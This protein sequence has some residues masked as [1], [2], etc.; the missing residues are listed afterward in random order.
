MHHNMAVAL[1]SKVLEMCKEE[2][3]N[4]DGSFNMGLNRCSH[5]I[6]QIEIAKKTQC[7]KEVDQLKYELCEQFETLEKLRTKKRML[8]D[9]QTAA[10]SKLLTVS[11]ALYEVCKQIK[12]I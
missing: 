3:E 11:D 6:R 1:F 12:G 7:S 4:L 10:E 9:A 2:Y 8:L 5:I